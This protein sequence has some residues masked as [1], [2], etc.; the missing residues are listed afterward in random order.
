LTN[1]VIVG[2]G[3]HGREVLD[4]VEALNRGESRFRLLGFLD[5]EG[6]DRPLLESR[7]ARV[8]GPH[9]ELA[10]LDASYV[11]GI[12]SGEARRRVDAF[13]TAAGREAA[14]L[15][16]PAASVGAAVRL[17]PGTVLWPGARITTD[18]ELGRHVHLNL[19]ATVSH[20]CRL[21]DYVTLSP[22]AQVSGA[23]TLGEGV[24]LG[25]GAVVIQGATVGPRTVVGAGAVVLSDLPPDVV[26]VGV[27]ARV[28]ER[29]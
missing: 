16:H 25:A 8:L 10:G 24:L 4:V 19:N 12:G 23:V 15:V 14:V 20:D 17:G 9:T 26:A 1:L 27:P 21:G 6:G 13:A 11:V 28:L 2:A 29:R 22:G 18:V 5:D 3:G 7:G